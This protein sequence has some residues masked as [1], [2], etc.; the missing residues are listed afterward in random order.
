MFAAGES[1]RGP[2]Q[3]SGPHPGNPVIDSLGGALHRIIN[4]HEFL[5]LAIAPEARFTSPVAGPREHIGGVEAD[6]IRFTDSSG[7]PVDFLYGVATGLPLGF[8]ATT[9]SARGETAVLSQFDDWRPVGAIRLPFRVRITHGADVFRYMIADASTE[10]L[11]D[12]AFSA[13]GRP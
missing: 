2:W 10:W 12:S 5:L 11:A 8:R 13:P 4:G 3:Q 9:R 6:V 7:W 1:L